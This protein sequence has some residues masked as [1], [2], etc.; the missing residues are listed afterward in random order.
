MSD[1]V[2]RRY[3]S[4]NEFWHEPTGKWVFLVDATRYRHI[5]EPKPRP[6]EGFVWITERLAYSDIKDHVDRIVRDM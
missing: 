3:G 6:S 2:I 4:I 5:T 1:F